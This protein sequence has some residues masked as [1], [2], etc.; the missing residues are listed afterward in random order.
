MELETR[1]CKPCEGGVSAHDADRVK[2]LLQEV[3]GWEVNGD[4]T[5][6]QKTFKFDNFHWTMA[7]VNAVAWFSHQEDHHPDL[8][9]GYNRCTIHYSTHAIGGLSD[10]DFICAA[11]ADALVRD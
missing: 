4:S 1:H 7:F 9:V 8:E 3:D 11:K 6:I 5:A 10:N 2:E